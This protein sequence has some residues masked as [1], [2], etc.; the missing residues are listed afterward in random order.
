VVQLRQ[1]RN[2]KR[3]AE[4]AFANDWMTWWQNSSDQGSVWERGVLD[5]NA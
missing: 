5:K 4:L 2:N 1:F 3:E